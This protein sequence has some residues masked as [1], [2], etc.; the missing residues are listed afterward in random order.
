MSEKHCPTCSCFQSETD[1]KSSGNSQ[2]SVSNTGGETP[3]HCGNAL[4]LLSELDRYL[5]RHSSN[6]IHPKSCFHDSIKE[7]L[8]SAQKTSVTASVPAV[9]P[10][11][12]LEPASS[13]GSAAG[14]VPHVMPTV[15]K[16]PQT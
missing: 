15:E 13:P 10:S 4:R 8:S 3:P 16:A 2:A 11:I 7:V 6:L 12:A 14:T 1:G 5:S 9:S